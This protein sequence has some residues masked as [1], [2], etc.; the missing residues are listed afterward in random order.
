MNESKVELVNEPPP[1]NI[2][3]LDEKVAIAGGVI[4]VAG[5]FFSWWMVAAGV[6]T[7]LVAGAIYVQGSDSGGD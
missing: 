3:S 2:M 1:I 6:V 4:L 5:L 7:I